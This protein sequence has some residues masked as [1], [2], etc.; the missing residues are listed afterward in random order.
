MCKHNEK[1]LQANDKSIVVNVLNANYL[2]YAFFEEI[3]KPGQ[4]LHNYALAI[5]LNASNTS[6][7]TQ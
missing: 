1:S 2:L 7:L 4:H 6:A 3:C 5:E